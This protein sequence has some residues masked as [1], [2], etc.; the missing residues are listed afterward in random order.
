MTDSVDSSTRSRIM[1]SVGTR[2]TAPEMCVR[3]FLHAQGFRFRLHAKDLPGRPDIVLPKY[4]AVVFVH[5]CF[6]HQHPGCHKATVPASN[7]AFWLDKFDQNAARDAGN[8]R[9]LRRLGWRVIVLWECEVRKK[10]ALGRLARRL[11]AT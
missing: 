6:W 9:R 5:G 8:V 11:L 10:S 3:R 2:D 7:R 4:K 1:A